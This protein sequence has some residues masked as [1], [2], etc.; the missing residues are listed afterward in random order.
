MKNWVSFLFCALLGLGMLA[1]GLLVPSHLRAVD[2]TVL[3]RAA[4]DSPGFV[5]QGLA[6][7]YERNLGAAQLMFKAAEERRIPR[8]EPLQRALIELARQDPMLR[9]HGF[10]DERSVG[11]VF[12]NSG[13][14]AA[15]AGAFE[16]AAEFLIRAE[17]RQAALQ[18]LENSESAVVRDLLHFR[19]MTNTTLFPASGTSSGQ[20]VDAALCM[21]GLLLEGGHVHPGF[22]NS[23]GRLAVGA[24][25]GKS[26][27]LEQVL[28]DMLSLGQRFNW[29]Q[30]LAFVGQISNP[31]T[32]RL[33][34]NHVR[35]EEGARAVIFA[36][37]QVSANPAGVARYL[38]TFGKTG[39]ADLGQS[40][41]Y[42][43]AGMNELL[44]R[45]QRLHVSRF[46][47]LFVQLSLR[48]PL[49]G[50]TVKWLLFFA[51]GFL[52]SIAVHFA[53]PRPASL[54][55][56]LQVGG[57]FI[58]RAVLFGLGSLL[59]LLLVS[60]PFLAQE[61]QKVEF[62]FRVQ[63]PGLGSA[64]PAGQPNPVTPFMNPEVLITML[65]FFVLQALLYIVCLVKL[66]EIR[67]QKVVARM[68]L[69]LLEN[70]EHLFDAGLYLGFLGTIISLILVSLGV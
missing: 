59:V 5:G 56:P 18:A 44:E 8:R 19:T 51:G 32:L 30:L 58:A 20:A 40:L 3:E 2:D 23:I 43:F 38:S 42:G 26:G 17:N 14:T 11:Q 69:K 28:L 57:I 4:L 50:L 12:Q 63:L 21:T 6:L 34:A 49:L 10:I 37:V 29:G 68:K 45:N 39:A 54:E 64:A 53:L 52:L 41:R 7:V 24:N 27:P 35:T 33:L 9:K 48:A 36:A 46:E 1:C 70:E 22:S 65:I 15:P 16:T 62:P 66:A 67:R 47:P 60:E 31:E 25:A 13:T 55:R 61:S